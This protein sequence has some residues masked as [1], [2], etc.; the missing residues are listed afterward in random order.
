MKS[1]FEA[2]FSDVHKTKYSKKV[3]GP[4]VESQLCRIGDRLEL[5]TIVCAKAG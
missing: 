4:R 2:L 1:G 3:V 5:G